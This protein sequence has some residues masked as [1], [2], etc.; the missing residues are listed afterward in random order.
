VRR[1]AALLA[2]L[3]AL[4]GGPTPARAQSGSAGRSAW[5]SVAVARLWESPSSPRAVDAPA[6]A[7][8]VRFRSWL[9]AMSL[10]Q[11]RA[12]SSHSDTEALLGERVVVTGVR[13]AW[14]HVV[15][16]D[17]PSQKDPRG[18][19]GWV[20]LRQ[21]TYTAP[22][23]GGPVASVVRRTAWLRT[24][25]NRAAKVVEVSYGTVL[26][27]VSRDASLVRVRTP[28]GAVR[29][30]AAR[31]VVV[32]ARGDATRPRTGADLVRSARSF[33]GLPYLWGGLSGFG[34]D[35]SGLTWLDYRVHGRVISRDALPQSR[36]GRVVSR[37]ALRPGDLVFYATNGLVH[38]VTMYAGGGR[39]VE[40]PHTGAVVR[41]VPVRRFEY[42]G[43]RRYPLRTAGA[44][45]TSGSVDVRRPGH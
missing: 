17:Q 16:P 10:S 33:S 37:A 1:L 26:P 25:T 14:A 30:V 18:Y 9:A 38:H 5:V 29:R 31:D 36:H 4:V 41:T 35:C 7:A 43:A 40:A 20:P 19:P 21:I 12:L 22:P 45:S 39:M 8:P 15:V 34:L 2:L 27:V 13:G 44:S 3:V 24:D 6:L 42:H 28:L 32:H 11:R 23:S